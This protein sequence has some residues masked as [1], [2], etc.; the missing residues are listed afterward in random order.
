MLLRK[1]FKN[2]ADVT[3]SSINY[4]LIDTELD[5]VFIFIL[6][7]KGRASDYP[8]CLVDANPLKHRCRTFLTDLFSTT[9]KKYVSIYKKN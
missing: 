8:L 5:T 4:N 7:Q 3:Y 2:T 1:M 6:E 9:D